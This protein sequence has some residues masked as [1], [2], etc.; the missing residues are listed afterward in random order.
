MKLFIYNREKCI[1]GTTS[2]GQR[3]IRMDR[4]GC[5]FLSSALVQELGLE[6]ES[7]T[8]L[9]GDE[10]DPRQW[11]FLCIVDDEGGFPVR[12]KKRKR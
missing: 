12:L 1:S 8:V 2:A 10:D 5:I 4:N 11:L 9:V 6:E 7:I 3:S